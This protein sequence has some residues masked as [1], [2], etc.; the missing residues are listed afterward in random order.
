[1]TKPPSLLPEGSVIGILGGGQ[2]GRMT[3]I[4]AAELGY[5]C[6]VFAPPGDAP[7]T[8]IAA[9]S[10]RAA[11]D[12]DAALK[13]F[14]DA[15]DTVTSEF[16]NVPAAAMALIAETT[17]VSPGVAALEVAQHRIAEKTLARDLG[18]ATPAFA[19]ITSAADITAPLAA[20][21]GGAILK[22]CRLGYDGKGQ[23]RISTSA[24]AEEGFARLASDDCILEERIDFTAEASFL[25]A[26]CADG[27][28]AHFPASI[29]SHENGILALSDAPA[30]AEILPPALLREGQQA[31]EAMANHLGLVGL[32]AMET[33]ITAKGLVFN[34]IAPRPH[35]SFHW[36]IEGT[37]TSQF[38]QLV[39]AVTGLPL[40]STE[41]LGQWQMQNILGEHMAILKAAMAEP[42]A[43]IHRYGKAEPRPGRK[44]A[45][46]TRKTG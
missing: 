21:P 42:G 12:D 31:V 34:E 24:D 17:P 4:A 45:H 6:H 5:R 3:A 44:M 16:E 30:S 32:L 40:G 22:T 27:R 7:A 11:Y 46:I 13:A 23:A 9:F 38:S 14:A 20:M 10:T 35:N 28:I 15:V 2:L 19:A 43:F 41:A 25:V 33:F 8:D 39:R 37:A 36:T 29:N 18:I 1:M 26:R